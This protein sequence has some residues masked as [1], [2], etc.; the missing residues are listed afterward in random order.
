MLKQVSVEDVAILSSTRAQCEVSRLS[1]HVCLGLG[2]ESHGCV[3]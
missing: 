1:L 2:L 3:V